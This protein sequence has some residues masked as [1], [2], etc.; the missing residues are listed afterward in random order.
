[1]DISPD[2]EGTFF[3]TTRGVDPEAAPEI[4]LFCTKTGS[5]IQIAKKYLSNFNND[6]MKAV[7]QYNTDE[8][9]D[10]P[11]VDAQIMDLITSIKAELLPNRTPLA[12]TG[13]LQPA[14]PSDAY[15][16]NDHLSPFSKVVAG[17]E[18][19]TPSGSVHSDDRDFL[20]NPRITD[21]ALNS[22]SSSRANSRRGSNT[23]ISVQSPSVG[24]KM[25]L[26]YPWQ[27]HGNTEPVSSTALD[28][29]R[30]EGSAREV[31]QYPSTTSWYR[32]LKAE[33]K[34]WEHIYL[35][36]CEKLFR[37]LGIP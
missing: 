13:V 35:E 28:G 7:Q 23:S 36:G 6:L 8:S 26:V 22:G 20:R 30:G 3:C 11:D 29:A 16:P 2:P 32:G 19:E 21:G 17:N 1:M 10:Q 4:L 12:I 37:D 9:K 18:T 34:G 14:A 5:N 31:V 27:V 15:S 24:H 33:G 25:N